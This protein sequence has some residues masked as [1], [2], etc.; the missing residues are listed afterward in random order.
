MLTATPDAIA[1]TGAGVPGDEL[2]LTGPV[3]LAGDMFATTRFQPHAGTIRVSEK[4]LLDL[5]MFGMDPIGEGFE[6]EQVVVDGIVNGRVGFQGVWSR[7]GLFWEHYG[8]RSDGK[9]L[10]DVSSCRGHGCVPPEGQT[11]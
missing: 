5:L 10:Q 4:S 11:S 8:D 9:G 7:E 3:W 2:A 6:A 1:M